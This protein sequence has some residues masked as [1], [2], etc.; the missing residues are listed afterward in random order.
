MTV[1]RKLL[2]K[3]GGALTWS[4]ICEHHPNVWVCLLDVEKAADGSID[5]ARV[6]GDD[7]SMRQLRAHLGPPQPHTVGVHTSGRPL[8]SP[9][10]ETT[11]EI[12]DIVRPRR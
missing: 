9:R 1:A 5:S 3:N 8:L 7:P 2:H 12:R 4:Q 10:I 11:D 6:I